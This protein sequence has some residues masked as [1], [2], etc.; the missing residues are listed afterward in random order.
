[1]KKYLLLL[2]PF[3]MYACSQP[4]VPKGQT[5]SDENRQQTAPTEAPILSPLLD[6]IAADTSRFRL[7]IPTLGGKKMDY[8]LKNKSLDRTAYE[9]YVQDLDPGDNAETWK[10][11]S[12][13]ARPP[14]D[15]LTFFYVHLANWLAVEADGA[16]AQK[17]TPELSALLSS[18]TPVFTA[19]MADPSYPGRK[20]LMETYAYYL[21]GLSAQNA[22]QFS[23]LAQ[24]TL[25]TCQNCP[26][27]EQDFLKAFLKTV[28]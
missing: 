13:A 1:M 15:S 14:V 24:K 18:S 9:L 25:Q 2:L 20:E 16:V 17:I 12:L 4:G 6:E 8:F 3:F 11:L 26:K 5:Q 7:Y 22:E 27:A 28:Q 23:A 19:L 10:V 21:S